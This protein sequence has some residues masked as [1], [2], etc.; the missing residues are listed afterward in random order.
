MKKRSN[1]VYK[2]HKSAL[3][4]FFQYIDKRIKD[5]TILDVKHYF[6][7]ILNQKKVCLDTK[8]VHRS[9]LKSFFPM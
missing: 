1:Q 3:K 7:Y 4:Q 8:E 9:D 5:I 2:N 6:D